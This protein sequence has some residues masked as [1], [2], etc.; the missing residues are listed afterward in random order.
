MSRI[1]FFA[2]E[3]FFSGKFSEF[4][5]KN[6]QMSDFEDFRKNQ[7]LKI[8]GNW[9]FWNFPFFSPNFFQTFFIRASKKYFF[10]VE[11]FFRYSFDVEIQA[12]SIYDVFR[13]IPA[14]LP[15]IQTA[16]VTKCVSK[17]KHFDEIRWTGYMGSDSRGLI[18]SIRIRDMVHQKIWSMPTH[19]S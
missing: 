14:L 12:L 6:L 4:S 7:N 3:F 5:Q 13:T 19:C 2:I 17:L 10:R 11:I 1:F 15:S 18:K 8:L 9:D 16:L